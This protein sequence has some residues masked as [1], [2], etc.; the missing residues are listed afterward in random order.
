MNE[1]KSW[2]RDYVIQTVIGTWSTTKKA[3]VYGAP[4]FDHNVVTL[5]RSRSGSSV[6]NWKNKIRY[7]NDATSSFSG[8]RLDVENFTGGKLVAYRDD[9]PFI[10][11]QTVEQI[12]SGTF[13]YPGVDSI[14]GNPTISVSFADNQ[15]RAAFLKKLIAAQ[16]SF[17]GGVFLGEI[18][19]TLH[20]IRNPAR[21][22]RELIDSYHTTVKKRWHRTKVKDR[23]RMV[24]DQWLE[25]SFGI[26]PLASDVDSAAKAL[27]ELSV[28]GGARFQHITAKGQD[29]SY[30][31]RGTVSINSVL[32]AS[33]KKITT[34]RAIVVYR[35]DVDT[36]PFST[37]QRA[38]SQ[39]GVDPF[40]DF[41]PTVWELIPYSFLVDY[42]TNIGEIINGWSFQRTG[43]RWSNKTVVTMRRV[44]YQEYSASNALPWKVG[45]FARPS[46]NAYRRSVSRAPY[47]GSFT[48]SLEFQIPGIGSTKWLNIA[49]LAK[50]RRI[51]D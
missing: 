35:G 42:F 4:S 49:A 41:V 30:V 20:L 32:H 39:L 14:V 51:V 37:T 1:S 3:V 22:I 28:N 33:C 26:L 7:H 40:R 13:P 50:M 21:G 45:Q 29:D 43:L 23:K 38:L 17:S 5:S 48:P 31:S 47:V 25:Y 6:R 12:V 44:S 18:R 19:E 24:A 27:A 36:R 2:K 46:F 15:A 9:R 10:N 11:N 8:T 34:D 16:Q